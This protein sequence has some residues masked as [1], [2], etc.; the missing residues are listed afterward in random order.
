M[1]VDVGRHSLIDQ[2]LEKRGE[3]N[4]V[5]LEKAVKKS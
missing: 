2:P 1:R 5:P 3:E 4:I